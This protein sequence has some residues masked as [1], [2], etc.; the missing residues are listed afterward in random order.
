MATDRSIAIGIDGLVALQRDLRAV[1]ADLPKDLRALN[2][3]V[4]ESVASKAQA[5]AVAHGG[6]LAKAAPAIKAGAEQRGAFVRLTASTKYPMV[7]GAEF[8]AGQNTRRIGK[9]RGGGIR[10]YVGFR[11]FDA[12]RGN[13]ADAGYAVYPTIRAENEH[14]V[15]A[16]SERLAQLLDRAFPG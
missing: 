4:A 13:G 12:W 11:Q 5:R 8:G 15:A 6:A 3:E 1:D 16:Y 7:L 10:S 2:L 9:V 14:I